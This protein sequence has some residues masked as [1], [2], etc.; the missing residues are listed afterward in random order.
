MAWRASA[1]VAAG[2]LASG[3]AALEGPLAEAV[4]PPEGATILRES[5]EDPGA[6]AAPVRVAGA[7][8]GPTAP[9][10]GRVTR[11]ALRVEGRPTPLGLVRMVERRLGALGFETVLRCAGE[12]CGGFAFR[13][14]IEV[15]PQ[16]AM[17]VNLAE[18][19]QLTMRR[20]GAEG[21]TVI[22][23]LASRFGETTLAQLVVVEDAEAA[24]VRSAPPE[25][26]VTAPEAGANAAAPD[27]EA[28]MAA[29]PETER[30][31]VTGAEH[32]A[33]EGARGVEALRA[34]LLERGRVVLEGLAF[35][36]GAATFTRESEAVLDRAA[37]ALRGLGDLRV[38]VVGH[39]DATGSLALN[40]RI[41]LGRA[42]SVRDALVERGV[43][44]GRLSAEGVGYLA[45]RASNAEEDGRARNRRVELVQAEPP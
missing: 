37:E 31:A 8:G 18:F 7:E 17:A 22:S 13:Y 28:A 5:V 32:A 14:G 16:P 12:A 3:A 9:L 29:E 11:R 23:L 38:A 27:A 30:S 6:Y 10:E 45:P 34:A 41:S 25:A 21:A 36:T 43:G 40:Q 42:R 4:A 19:R 2:L 35:E 33:R 24:P 39:T 15:M 20:E 26:P 1:L 44:A